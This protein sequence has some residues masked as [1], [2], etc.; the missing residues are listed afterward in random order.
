MTSLWL[1]RTIPDYPAPKDGAE[2]DIV[3]VGA[4]LTGLTTAL[5]LARAGRS[6]AVVEARHLGA[7]TTGNT[8]A[9]VS[10]LQGTRL[11][12]IRRRHSD[13]IVRQYVEAN[14]EGQAWLRRYCEEHSV[15]VQSRSAYTYASTENGIAAVQRELEAAQAAGLDVRW[16][17]DTELPYPVRGAVELADQAQIDPLD[18]LT[19]MAGDLLDRPGCVMYQGA[20]VRS[21]QPGRPATIGT[22]RATIRAGRVVLATGI[23]IMDRGV[24]WARLQPLRS[25]ALAF[26]V[27]GPVPQGMYL[28]ADSPTR[29]VRSVPRGGVELL[30]TGGNG[31]VVGRADHPTE[32]VQDL[33]D[34][35]VRH[36]TGAEL[37][38]SWSAQDYHSDHELPFVGPLTPRDDQV[39]LA[40]GF[41]KWGMTMAVASAVALSSRILGGHTEWAAALETWTTR[42]LSGAPAAA[43]AN[44]EVG[45]EMA[46]GWA[47]SMLTS[48]GDEP[49]IEGQG[50]VER[51]G[52]GPVAVCTVGGVTIQRSAVCTH[53]GGIVAW[54]DVERSWD[55][56]LHGSRFAADGSV[57]EGPTTEDLPVRGG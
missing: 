27:P 5:L 15:P 43:K 14:S 47:R 4:G 56:P 54:N 26:R 23:P 45:A 12:A 1:D 49:P 11:S 17:T 52:I 24:F 37:T 48:A 16:V 34:W 53:L 7:G 3:V 2:Y 31:H 44:L 10:L 13:A 51:H 33:A 20:R 29:S 18:V 55:C 28:S 22:D 38:H 42:E 32:R 40:T 8:T 30:L 25:Y 36:F 57:L 41:D 6:V 19:A 21:V 35:T 39:L 9:K 46:G 50:R